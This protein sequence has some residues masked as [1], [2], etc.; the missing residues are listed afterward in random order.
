MKKIRL[1]IIGFGKHGSHYVRRFLE[2]DI[3][4]QV[5]LTALAE[6]N[7]VRLNWARQHLKNIALFHNAIEMLDSGLIDACLICIPHPDHYHYIRK[8]FE[9]NIHVLCEKPLCVFA[10]DAKNIIKE[11]ELNYPHLVFAV[12]LNQR[13][14]PLHQKLK[15]LLDNNTYGNIRRIDWT[16]TNWYRNQVYFD[17]SYWHA[18]W[19]GECG[20]LIMNQAIHQL[21]LWQW[22]FGLPDHV[23]AKLGFAKAHDIEADDEATVFFEYDNGIS[24]TLIASSNDLSGQNCLKIQTDKAVIIME[25]G[26]ILIKEEIKQIV[27]S[28]ERYKLMY[29]KPSCKETEITS[30]L[31]DM[32]HEEVVNQFADAIITGQ[33]LK[34][35][36]EEG[37]NSIILSNAIYLSSFLNKSIEI[38]CDS[39]MFKEELTN[40]IAKSHLR[41]SA[42]D[43]LS[44]IL[45]SYDDK[46]ETGYNNKINIK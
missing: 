14:N 12:M 3:C 17:E 23:Y 25:N 33:P 37:L 24:G 6:K 7:P 35:K 2:T 26:K 31:I 11:H 15:Q 10:D 44:G 42:L 27:S 30:N 16:L 9:K 8:C 28:N 18:T 38:P 45:S 29:K 20:G 41:L 4:K 46:I 1:G 36:A 13:V 39:N 21:D 40:R 32:K 34:L 19:L 5:K 43:S 22:F